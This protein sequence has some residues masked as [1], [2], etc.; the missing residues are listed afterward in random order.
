MIQPMLWEN[1]FLLFLFLF[2]H[3][4][5]LLHLLL[6]HFLPTLL[7]ILAR[8]L[9]FC[10]HF[11]GWKMEKKSVHRIVGL[12]LSLLIFYNSGLVTLHLVNE[13]SFFSL[14]SLLLLTF[15]S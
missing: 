2:V 12:F 5:V 10:F 11:Y 3:F 9:F 8:I 13:L 14:F 6:V 1:N 4:L 15:S 7:L